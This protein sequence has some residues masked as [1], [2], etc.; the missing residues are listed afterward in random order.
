MGFNVMRFDS[1]GA[2]RFRPYSIRK[3]PAPLHWPVSSPALSLHDLPPAPRLG[4]PRRR[5]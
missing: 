3:R 1:S 5:R 4:I 2:R